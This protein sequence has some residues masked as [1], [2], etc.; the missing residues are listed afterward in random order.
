MG[1]LSFFVM[2]TSYGSHYLQQKG[3]LKVVKRIKSAYFKAVL[4]QE[5]AWFDQVSYTEIASRISA[6]CT[7]IE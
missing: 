2:L 5:S 4:E 1:V 6:E 3:S 7:A